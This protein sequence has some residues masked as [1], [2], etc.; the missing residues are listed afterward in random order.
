MFDMPRI[1]PR[2]PNRPQHKDFWLLSDIEL[3][4]DGRIDHLTDPGERQEEFTKVIKEVIDLD[5]LMYMS[6]GRVLAAISRGLYFDQ[7]GM[8]SMYIDGFL[9]GAHFAR[10]QNKTNKEQSS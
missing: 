7:S 10:K 5:S 8:N 1:D 4:L 2:F 9:A 6:R 3:D